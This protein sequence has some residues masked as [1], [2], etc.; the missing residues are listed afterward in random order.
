MEKEVSE[1]VDSA[2]LQ[3]Q[4]GKVL[5]KDIRKAVQHQLSQVDLVSTCSNGSSTYRMCVG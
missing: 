3:P 2:I 5:D 1:K 4:V